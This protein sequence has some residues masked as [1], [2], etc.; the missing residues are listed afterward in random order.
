MKPTLEVLSD[1]EL[2]DQI[3]ESREVMNLKSIGDNHFIFH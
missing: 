2:L 1:A 3:N